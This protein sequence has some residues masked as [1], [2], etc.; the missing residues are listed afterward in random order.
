[1]DADDAP[2][3]AGDDDD[4]DG[5]CR[6]LDYRTAADGRRFDT[7]RAYCLVADRFVEPM[8]AD[9]CN[10]RHGL[11]PAEHCEIYRANEGGG[12]D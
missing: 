5:A 1:M 3:S 7:P 6:H 12:S 8:R 4:G 11:V 10:A 2:A 9:V